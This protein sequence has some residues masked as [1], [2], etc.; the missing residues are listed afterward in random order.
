MSKN[1]AVIIPARYA[2]SRFPGKPLAMIGS[3]PMIYYVYKACKLS[4]NNPKVII[5]TDDDRIYK[6]CKEFVERE[7]EVVMTPSSIS[8]GSER[9]A[10]VAGNLNVDYVVNLQGDEPLISPEF[11]DLFIDDLKLLDKRVPVLTLAKKRF[12]PSQQKMFLDK[13]TV[14][15]IF[16]KNNEAVYFSRAAIPGGKVNPPYFYQHVGIY[17]YLKD[18][19]LDFT[20]MP[21]SFYETQESLEQLRI[22]ENCFSIKIKETEDEFIGVD[23]PDDIKIVKSILK[24]KGKLL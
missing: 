13:N 12:L 23:V 11:L 6:V 18:F 8:T 17:G 7:F 21:L 4:K 22:I 14:K 24:E 16:D 15:L 10:I 9:C 19:L 3:K 2:S 20:K 1:V 5:A